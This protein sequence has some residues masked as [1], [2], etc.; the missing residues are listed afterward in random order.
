MLPADLSVVATPLLERATMLL[1]VGYS[2]IATKIF[3]LCSSEEVTVAKG[4]YALSREIFPEKSL[5]EL[6]WFA[7][8]GPLFGFRLISP[9]VSNAALDA[10]AR[11]TSG[12]P[13]SPLELL[14]GLLESRLPRELLL[15]N[16]AARSDSAIDLDVSDAGY[17]KGGS[18]YA[19]VLS[20][21]YGGRSITMLPILRAD[22]FAVMALFPAGYEL[23][24]SRIEAHRSLFESRALEL[25]QAIVEAADL[26]E[27]SRVKEQDVLPETGEGPTRFN[28][29]RLLGATV[30]EIRRTYEVAGW[31]PTM[32]RL[33]P[34]NR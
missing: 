8:V 17:S 32:P 25:S 21:L 7:S 22:Q 12:A 29:G 3:E 10:L 33:R 4:L 5:R 23:I 14:G 34:R 18:R 6:I 2:W 31:S 24:V 27:V 16:V 1:E 15:M 19:F 28:V 9:D 30:D 20:S 13:V 11:N 26:F